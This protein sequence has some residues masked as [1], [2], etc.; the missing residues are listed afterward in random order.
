MTNNYS[1]TQNQIV[2]QRVR[3][4][5]GSPAL[6]RGLLV[7]LTVLL[8]SFANNSFAQIAV[9]VDVP[10]NTTP[11]LAA[12]Y[13]SLS[14][15]LTAVNAI[16]AMSGPVVLTCSGSEI[17]PP[18]GF[19]VGSATLNPVLNAASSTMIT[20][21]GPATINAGVGTA[22]PAS[23]A[24]DGMLKLSGADWVTVDG[25]TLTDGNTT[26]PATMEFGIALFKLSLSD[27]CRNNTIK[28][29]VITVKTIN[30]ASGTS[31][32][33]EGSVGILMINSTAA[34][35][36][37]ALT[38]TAAVGTNSSN[39]FYSNTINGGNYGMGLIGFA[40]VTPFTTC[41]F[42]NDIGGSSLA[43]ANTIQNFGGGAATN[44]SAGIRT[45]A[46]YSINVSF[47]TVN[48]NTGANANH[49]T[50]FRGIY[51]NTA[52][53]ANATINNNTVTLKSGATTSACTAI[54]NQS[55][56]TAAS[57]T[58]SISNNTVSGAN[59]TATT[60]VWSGIVNGATATTVNI[61]GN[62]MTGFDLAG[63]GTHVMIETGSP[64]TATANSN[65]II[66]VTR[67]GAS[68]S[69][70]IIKTTSPT[71]FTA[72]S[73]TIDGLKWTALTSTGSIS[74]IYGLSSAVNVTANSN[75]I[76]NLSI[77]TTGTIIGI[78][79]FGITGLKTFQNNQI[80]NF[81]TTAGGAGGASFTGI[82]ESTGS[83]N[84]F[85]GNQIYSLNSTGTTGGTGGT[86]VG[87]TVSSGT[88][89]NIYNNKIYDLS[90]TSTGP[91]VAG[92]TTSGG[93]TNNVYNNLIGDL[94]ATAANLAN[95]LIGLNIIGGT[96]DNIYYNTV[97]INGTSS[98]A[99]FG[100]SAISASTTP[101]LNLRN[102][103]FVNTST[104]NTT[105]LTVAYRR[106]STTLTSYASTS[107]N[108]LFYAGTPS[109]SKLI[110][111]DGT[112]SDQTLA[113]YKT[114][115]AS[116]DASSATEN[117]PF[118]S[119]TGSSATFLHIN[120]A[121][122][123]QIE[124]GGAPISGFTTDYDGD[125][126]N[127]TAPDMGADEFTGTP[128]TPSI[129]S[130]SITP[131]GSQ[132]TTSSRTITANVTNVAA[133]ASVTLNY[134]FNGTAQS[135]VTMTGGD[136]SPGATSNWTGI[137]PAST[138]VNAV[139]TWSVTASDGTLSKTTNGTTY[140][141]Q[142]LT[143]YTV[144]AT[145]SVNPVC[146]GSPT[147]LSVVL[148]NPQPAAYALPPAVSNPTTDEDFG[149]ITITQGVT[150]ILNNTT[151]GGSLIGT[152][153]TGTGTAGSY[154]NFTGFGPYSLTV[155][156]LYNFSVSSITQGGS[157]GNAMAIFIDYN[158]N[159]VFTD[160]GEQVYNQGATITGP[161]TSTGSFTVPTSAFNGLARMRVLVNEG[162]ISGPTITPSWGE[163]EEYM[164]NISSPNAGGGFNVP[165]VTAYSWSDGT[166]T[167]G[168]T[169]PLTVNPTANTT[170]T[171]T[172]TAS[173]CTAN[174]NGVSITTLPLPASPSGSG[175]NTCGTNTA[176]WTASSS[177]GSGESF[178][179]YATN[180]STTV[181]GTGTPYQETISATTIRYLAVWNG[182]CESLR[183]P[184]TAN[185]VSPDPV[186][187]R[188]NGSTTPAAVCPNSN[189]ALTAVQTGSTNVY[190]YTWTASPQA[191]SGIPV[192]GTVGQNISVTPT[193]AGTYVY[194]VNAVDGGCVTSSG[195]TIV[196]SS[197]P[198]ID[199]IKAVPSSVCLGQPAT[200]NVYS[201]GL[202]SGPQ[203][204]PS[205]YSVVG[206]STNNADEQIFGVTF[207]TMTNNQTETCTS[208]YSDYTT[209]I[210]AP[211][212]TAGQSVPFSVNSN[213]CD[214]AT[215]FSSG[216]SIFIDYNRNGVFTDPGE[217]AYTT[218]VTTTQPSIRSGNI[219]IPM[220]ATA[221]LTR[222]RV[223]IVESVTS[224]TEN[225]AF[226]WGEAEDYAVNIIGVVR[227]DP[228]KTYSWSPAGGSSFTASVTP[229]ATTTYTVTVTDPS[230]TCVNT[231]T[232]GVTTIP[233]PSTPT[234]TT[235]NQCG[236]G[237]PAASVTSTTGSSSP[238]FFWY[239]GTGTLLQ[240]PPLATTPSTFY[241]ND[242]SSSTLTNSSIGGA[243]S[244]SGG[245]LALQPTPT[246]SGTGGSITVNANGFN[247][248][249]FQTDFDMTITSPG[250]SVADGFSYVLADD[251]T[252]GSNS[253]TP[254]AE[255][256][257]GSKLRLCFM[258]YNTTGT[259]IKGIYL[260]Y[261]VTAT[262]L[263]TPTTPGILAYSSNVSWVP[264]TTTPVASHITMTINAAGQLTLVV[265]GVTIF[266]NVQLPSGYLS[267]NKSTWKHIISS[268]SGGVAGGF[269]MDNLVI[270]ANNY[271]TGYTTYQLPITATTT[272]YVSELYGAC[273]S[274]RV[275]VTANVNAP[276]AIQA[277]ASAST[278][279]P[280]TNLTLTATQT[281]FVNGNNYTY[282]WNGTAGGGA[283]NTAGGSGATANTIVQATTPG[284]KTYTVT[285]TDGAC[286]TTSSVVVNIS[287]PPN[288]DSVKASPSSVC[289]GQNSTLSVY[290]S[291]LSTGPQT[292]PTGYSV[293]GT[294]TNNADEQI[295][296]VSFGSM[297]NT[298]TE[299]CTTNYSDYTTS[300]P[301][302]TVTAGQSVPFSV[303]SNEC[304]GATFFSS[305]LS[306]FIDFNRDG[307]FLD[308]G[309]Q[310]YTTT[311]TTQ[312]PSIRS[313]NIIIP[314]TAVGGLTRMRVII[315]E[316]VI[317]PAQNQAFTWGEAEDYAVNIIGVVRQDPAKTYAWSPAGGTSFNATVTPTGTTT[318]TVA[319]N[320]TGNTC[321]NY[322]TVTVTSLPIPA[323]PT[324]TNSTQ[325]CAGIP[326]ASV[327]GS[328]GI[329]KWYNGSSSGATLLQTG[330]STYATSISTTTTFY[331]SETNSS[332]GCEGPRAAVTATVNADPI[333]A[334]ADNVPHCLGGAVQLSAAWTPVNNNYTFN[335]TASPQTGSGIPSGGT[336]GQNIT[337][338]PTAAGTYI[339]TVTSND[340]NTPGCGVTS[341]VSV[342]VG[343]LPPIVNTTATPSTICV[344]SSSTL[345]AGAG[346]F[347][348]GFSTPQASTSTIGGNTGNPYRS[349]NG[350]N[351][352]I[353]TQLLYTASELTAAGLTSGPITSIG[354]YTTASSTGTVSNFTIALGSTSATSLSTTFETTPVTT[355]FNQAS[356]S[357]AASGLNLHT[358]NAG[359]FA[360]NGTSN[361][362]VNICQTNNITGTA[363]VQCFTP[364]TVS[365]NH[366]ASTTTGCTNTTGLTVTNKPI[367]TFGGLVGTNTTANFNWVWNPGALSGSSVSVSPASNTT[368]TVTATDP[369]TGCTST[370]SVGV[371]V[372]PVP[373]APAVNPSTAQVCNNATVTLVAT[374]GTSGNTIRWYNVASG[375]AIR[376]TGT[377]FTTPVQSG[378][379]T[380]Y[381]AE[382]NGTCEGPRTAVVV[383][384]IPAPTITISNP[385]INHCGGLVNDQLNVT[386]SNPNYVYTWSPIDSLLNYTGGAS[387][388]TNIYTTNTFTVTAVD[389]GS[390]C[391]TSG[392]TTVT[393]FTFTTVNLTATP[394]AICPGGSSNL[395][396]GVVNGN[397]AVSSIAW[398]PHPVPASGVTTLTH[399]GV[400]DVP[401][402]TGSLD[403][404]GWFNQ[405][406]GFNFNFFN[407]I[408]SSFHVSTNGNIQFDANTANFSTSFSP[409]TVPSTNL[410]NAFVGWDWQDLYFTTLGSTAK[411][412][413]WVDGTT[414]NRVL[415]VDY[416]S[417]PGFTTVG[418]QKG[419]ILLYE[420]T[421]VVETHLTL[422]TD[423]SHVKVCGVENL[424]GTVGAAA[425]GRNGTV[426]SI[427]SPEAWR[428]QPP[429]VYTFAW[430]PNDG[431]LD[432]TSSGTPV[433][434]PAATTTYTVVVTDPFT[435]CQNSYPVTVT[436][437]PVPNAPVI[438]DTTVCG[439]RSFTLTAASGGPV[440]RWYNGS[441]ALIFT[442]NPYN[443]PVLSAPSNTTYSVSSFD[444]CE[445]AKTPVNVSVTSAPAFD[446]GAD[447]TICRNDS[448]TLSVVTGLGDYDQFTWSPSTG[449]SST[450]G[451]TVKASPAA[452]TTYT[453]VASSS[454]G[455]Q[456]QNI[457]QLT[458]TVNQLPTITSVTST[459]SPICS[460]DSAQLNVTAVPYIASGFSG[461]YLLNSL[462]G[463]TYAPLS[464]AGITTIT[465]AAQLTSGF[466]TGSQDD[467]GV[468]ISLPFAFTYNGTAYTQMTMST[469]GWIGAGSGN[470][471]ITA[472]PDRTAGNLFI[473][474][475]PN[476][477][478]AAWFKDMGANFGAGF[479]GSMRHGLTG[480]DV[481][482][483]QWDQAC[484]T[485]FSNTTT[486]LI[487][488]QINIYGPASS[489]PGK[490]EIIYGPTLGTISF[491]ASEGIEN[492]T[493]GSGNYINA[494]NGTS[495]STATAT[496]WPGN[497]N[498]YSFTPLPP[499][500]LTYA[501]T[502]SGTLG[503]GGT[504]RNPKAGPAAS[505]TYTVTVSETGTG[506]SRI[507]NVSV[508]V[509]PTPTPQ[510]YPGDSV[511]CPGQSFY[512]KVRD[513][514]YPGGTSYP[515]NSYPAG[516]TFDMVG[517]ANNVDAQDS[518]PTSGFTSFQVIVHLPSSLGGCTATSSIANITPHV[519][520]VSLAEP[521]SPA[522][523]GSNFGKIKVNVTGTAPFHYT[524]T[525][526]TNTIRDIQ[527]ISTSDSIVNLTG[528]FYYLTVIDNEGNVNPGLSC[529]YGP[530]SYFVQSSGGPSVTITSV[531]DA[532]CF[533]STDGSAGAF[534]TGGTGNLTY[535]W[536]SASNTPSGNGL[537][538]DPLAAGN[539]YVQVTD[540]NL[541]V[542]TAQFIIGQ[543]T[544]IVLTPGSINATCGNND[545]TA[546]VQAQG[547]TPGYSYAW[548]NNPDLDPIH[549]IGTNSNTV[550]GLAPGVYYV[551]VSDLHGCVKLASVTV[552]Q[553]SCSATLNLTAFIEGYYLG[554]STMRPIF[555]NIWDGTGTSPSATDC[556]SIFIELRDVT[557][558]TIIVARDSAILQT[559]GTAAFTLPGTVTG[560]S[561]WLAV[562]N[563]GTIQTWSKLPITFASITA[564]NFSTASTQAYDDAVNLPMKEVE[565]GIWSL[566]SG[567][568][569]QDGTVDGQDANYVDN[570]ATNFAFGY[571]TS[572]LNGDGGT[573]G[574]DANY[575]DNN[576]QLFLFTA[577]P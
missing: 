491:A 175:S 38:P 340:I 417:V 100:S 282:V 206:T 227:Q 151:S 53:S 544:E 356:F 333:T 198:N 192:G 402:S 325:P 466:S 224:P 186:V 146:S 401:L 103:I 422:V 510:V 109:A 5:N 518:V 410:P 2:T 157:F 159:G 331:V 343:A 334:S 532:N 69:W 568:I 237:V 135:P 352:Q 378:D 297:N 369:A 262:S 101:T 94:R 4:C 10:T 305:G 564:Y 316:S 468:L 322:G 541:C 133:L 218:S 368:Y 37:T 288:I 83:T 257:S 189:V 303:S 420:T 134:A 249:L 415:V 171:A 548:Y 493:G 406:I 438:N 418:L 173:G 567:D 501:W 276:D 55:G 379:S 54:E 555:L 435:N 566:Y 367:V 323:A 260:G 150:T 149:N 485:G 15:A 33:I 540:A 426:W 36:T 19:T 308:A 17:A 494:L 104:P 295:F 93:T 84:D 556:D 454:T 310:A 86:I 187:A 513:L 43:T 321:T 444:L 553:N 351:N 70:R 421:G 131:A 470:A 452:T 570:D 40:G 385:G 353:R 335:W 3:N 515:Y 136:P 144:T 304:D 545:G 371:T 234:A 472:G 77:P 475:L 514:A 525:D 50:T 554:G 533:G 177:L 521:I 161:H 154:S 18:T 403:D 559:S 271:A 534:A 183:T 259:D 163:Y 281:A 273:E 299:T 244:I 389:A 512:Q 355:V 380:W 23:A 21:L 469:N 465:T 111:N 537:T 217:Q 195:V 130:V 137:L 346:S 560:G 337:V 120:T 202:S 60:G 551:V 245:A 87:I 407:T 375:G 264:T 314:M 152:I 235:S 328:G 373:A 320:E 315:A 155:G 317:S 425:P 56:S 432:N 439:S 398:A 419:Q 442:G 138:P 85:S 280:Y 277:S 22:T 115:V 504:I 573:D 44:P 448:I 306:I 443:T 207:G 107:N 292:N 542:D 263:F 451:S 117:P 269:S 225:Q 265:G 531:T 471:T 27:G 436:V 478:I 57:N 384:W 431:T 377:S 434:S 46:Q 487:S 374:I 172:I 11:N 123:T 242:F 196:I 191:N 35:A 445:S 511:L 180:V 75:I 153:G 48:N 143:G 147:N 376:T 284:T 116:R 563:R 287:T 405:P 347:L 446:A 381:A 212:V 201:S 571:N 81:F 546:S 296:E 329:F 424:A 41:D 145:A 364:A 505:T 24:P 110:F 502:P 167:V 349:G 179:W 20:L 233:L 450:T 535:E 243:A 250:T 495:T 226:T 99:V 440:Y 409:G 97:Y 455:L 476:N 166:S 210:A 498:G 231:A 246:S 538:S 327:S 122:A 72:N 344:G 392:T 251:G 342:T 569:N 121:I 490:I 156:T 256:G 92:I 164:V 95:A 211:T 290:S 6:L 430:T 359:S 30:N 408:Y 547:G 361:I 492:A 500:S 412:R 139:V 474:T 302:P 396:T 483:F 219:V 160:A 395:S 429:V 283:N 457:D 252:P 63:T 456:C 148:S 182:T 362:L 31:P 29:C 460:G 536:F 112:N 481:Y 119:T 181:L 274:P 59:T 272:F 497:G 39:K 89:N 523:C 124:G 188:A 204:N 358:F 298:Q 65:N 530:A 549:G 247:S 309:E 326:A 411:L 399:S 105:G 484:G 78:T 453:I 561:F 158:R 255:H 258:T 529:T 479:P 449:L 301:A 366:S 45:L 16:T 193:L 185:V 178:R 190:T 313:G 307:D 279:C 275:A 64:V 82:S 165:A 413:Y 428:F 318:Y 336:A 127:A 205:G 527:T 125:T 28:N 348:A 506:C 132:C 239:N 199:S 194:T 34:A 383:T 345:S 176:T 312:Q 572:D 108:N 488:F 391:A 213:E 142:P 58:I 528:G 14:S 49:A 516:T 459:P 62:I 170:Y 433:A 52:T 526:G 338:T 162:T 294:S 229:S 363:T 339:Y 522:P 291:G 519:L 220:T 350:T 508:N 360:W 248:T 575:I 128:A 126:R 238:L 26:N 7:I 324:A 222:M 32:M 266:N 129:N 462:T 543:P 400:Q 214:G 168:T 90:S 13:S 394:S 372:V 574:Q 285:A 184:V 577:H 319:V 9:T 61:N 414:P 241:S 253:T 565:P 203:T 215:F 557:D 503:N 197:P 558:P 441:N 341:T 118:L 393:D 96:T 76:R 330:G 47:N 473:S 1:I 113:A 223:I 354:F 458:I 489:S 387:A 365:D 141:D 216:L 539:Y 550:T 464:G 524:W 140:Q 293:V 507:G 67:S 576:S 404:G 68:G 447:R 12:S 228:A 267:A 509:T 390:G 562:F 42:S 278:I 221:G 232:V 463:Q 520:V 114:R 496:A 477:T 236:T 382:Y 286:V 332:T 200:L 106:S 423:N 88:T 169:N 370:A 386:S 25:L 80:Y 66:S 71:N 517:I 79:E 461:A 51:L 91:S 289:L 480:T 8:S 240:A 482:S 499:S 357:P 397:F 208:N 416:D 427:T 467:G 268:R 388:T 102:N 209:T 74:A 73:N 552:G 174:S 300:I 486:T 311:V 254:T 261:G 98:G 437:N 230:T 270:K